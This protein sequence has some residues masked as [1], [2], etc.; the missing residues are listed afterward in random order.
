MKTPTKVTLI[1]IAV[2]AVLV[3]A[4][5]IFTSASSPN[6]SNDPVAAAAIPDDGG[7]PGVAANSHVLDEVGPDAPTLVEYLDFECEACGA[8]YPYIEEIRAEY[9]GEIN[10]V[11]RYFPLPG[12]LNSMNA[13]VAV[14]AAAQQDR[15]EDMYGKLFETQANWG[16]QQTSQAPLFRTYAEELG[17][18]MAAFDAAVA[19]PA[20]EARVTEDLDQGRALGIQGTPTF[21]LDGQQLELTALTDLTDALDRAIAQ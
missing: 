3:V 8:F 21:F 14:E 1:S 17:L 7:L 9:Q 19:D 4:G 13:A 11:V 2:V 18:D 15:F 16:E 5:F 6:V 10:Y 12:H 20:T